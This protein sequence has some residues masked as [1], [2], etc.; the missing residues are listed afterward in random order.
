M[1]KRKYDPV[2]LKCG[3]SYIEDNKG[4]KPQCVIC[5]E[6]LA[7]ESMKPSKL[8]H[9]LD[10]KHPAC[11]DKPVAFFQR[12]HQKLRTSQKC[13]TASC[14]K[15]EE[16]LRA[17]YHVAHRIAKAKKPHTIAEEL[18]L[19]A[20]M[21]MVREVMG[22]SAAD[23]L[24]TI[25]LSND[26][27][28]QRIHDMSGNIKEQTTARVQASPYYALQMDEST[29][30][31]NHAILLVYV[32]HILDGDLQEQFLC[33]RDLPTTTKAEDI[34]NSVD[35][36]LSSV[37]LSWEYCVGITTD[38]AAA[39]TG[40]HS[41]VVKQILERAP[42]ATWN[43]CFLHREALAAKDMVT[44]L[45]EALKD[46]IKVVNHIKRSAKNSRCFSKLCKDLGSEHMQVLYHSEVRWLSR[47]KVLSRFYELK[48]EIAT[49]LS[50]NN[51]P[52]A[53]LFDNE[54]WLA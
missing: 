27:I 41:G 17:S 31:S 48:T 51:S 26:T 19:P 10:T 4:Q 15:Q 8:K 46:V 9:H 32:R 40:K 45:D 35:L 11:K 42:N 18:I 38:G 54:I 28:A 34:F 22:Q 12:Q 50:E 33:S 53:K 5:S 52:Y 14:S 37:G 39:M 24:K 49:F 47:G 23:K 43:H 13:L 30:V 36:Y 25:P 7:N 29:D 1:A 44:E 2:Y 6:V 21:D 16:A 20:P 3:F